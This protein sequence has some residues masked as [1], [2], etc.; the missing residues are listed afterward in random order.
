[1]RIPSLCVH[2]RVCA[3]AIGVLLAVVRPLGGQETER[4]LSA[5]RLACCS[6]EPFSE[7]DRL[8]LF[9]FVL[10]SLSLQFQRARTA[11]FSGH[12]PLGKVTLQP[13]YP[14]LLHSRRYLEPL[15]EFARAQQTDSRL[16]QNHHDFFT[17]QMP[18]S[19]PECLEFALS[20]P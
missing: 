10:T 19:L 3:K 14:S 20:C 2:K 8:S 5:I 16:F 12:R 18:V 13:L 17:L 4:H 6:K 9:E 1:M 7:D 11:T 15:C